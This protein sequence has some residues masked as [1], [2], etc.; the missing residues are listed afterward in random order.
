MSSDRD[1]APGT[2]PSPAPALTPDPA[3]A[4][5]RQNAE[6]ADDGARFDGHGQSDRRPIMPR[7]R[8]GSGRGDRPWYRDILR[9]YRFL[10][11]LLLGA[12]AAALGW[13]LAST[14]QFLIGA[15]IFFAA[16][17]AQIGLHVRKVTP[18]DL[19]RHAED[20]DEGIAIIMLLALAAVAV[21]V[22]GII[23]TL[24]AAE[25]GLSLRPWLAL[26]AV[27]L[28]W[29]TVHTV[30]AFHYAGLWYAREADGQ[31]AGGLDFQ[32]PGLEPGIWDFLY[33]SFT[34]GM[35]AQTA[36]VS[37]ASTHLRRVTLFHSVLSFFYNTVLVALAV[38]AAGNL[39]G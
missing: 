6:A 23:G 35:T 11:A 9:H 31:D 38:S 2:G 27:P 21:S 14:D 15:D 17:L 4:P 7:R 39:A 28:G 20:Q 19:R 24:K 1:N 18:E 26:A 22:L 3:P 32:Q 13:R 29:A 12:A 8:G 33:Y 37:V 10:I 30:M 16:F 34:I 5:A 36:D 25:P